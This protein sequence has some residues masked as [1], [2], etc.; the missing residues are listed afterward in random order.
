MNQNDIILTQTKK[1]IETF[2]LGLNL[3]P[4]A[5]HPFK[6]GKIRYTI[7]NG[8]DGE[9][10]AETLVR[11]LAYISQTPPSVSETTLIIIPDILKDFHEYLDFL[12]L[13]EDIVAEFELEGVIQV[14]SFHPD[15]QFEDTLVTDAENYTNRSPYPMVHLLREDS[16]TRA[17]EAFPEVGDIPAQNIETMNTLGIDKIKQMLNE[18]KRTP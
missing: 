8:E 1:W 18:L 11:E 16:V 2:V 10:L 12:D 6:N 3:C 7:F 13:A 5:R 17:I 15:Y 9:Q 4:F 14:A